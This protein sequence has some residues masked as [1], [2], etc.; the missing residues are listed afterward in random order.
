M[1][2][3]INIQKLKK[4]IVFKIIL[5]EICKRFAKHLNQKPGKIEN[6]NPDLK[7][8]VFWVHLFAS[9]LISHLQARLLTEGV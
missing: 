1:Y 9:N 4:F 8:W 6:P 5:L 2:T 3:Q 7:L